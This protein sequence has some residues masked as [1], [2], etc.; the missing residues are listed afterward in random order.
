MG[1]DEHPLLDLAHAYQALASSLCEYQLANWAEL[2]DARKKELDEAESDLRLTAFH[3]ISEDVMAVLAK[4][5]PHIGELA[6][7]TMKLH[8]A[9]KQIADVQESIAL[10]AEVILKGGALAV[11]ISGGSPVAIAGAVLAL[12][13]VFKAAAGGAG[14]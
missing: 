4:V 2:S 12:L 1:N 7:C 9:A 6:Q 8:K 10:A 14:Q 11:A 3:L 13:G 5:K